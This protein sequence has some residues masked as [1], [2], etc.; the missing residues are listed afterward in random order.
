MTQ[1]WSITTTS[2]FMK[3]KKH[4][5]LLLIHLKSNS[6]SGM[7][8]SLHSIFWCFLHWEGTLSSLINQRSVYHFFSTLAGNHRGHFI[9]ISRTL[10]HR[11]SHFIMLLLTKTTSSRALL[12]R[13]VVE[14]YTDVHIYRLLYIYYTILS[15]LG[16]GNRIHVMGL[17][18]QDRKKW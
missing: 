15:G 11:G 6:F 9:N 7:Q 17:H 10:G 13:F 1:I 14:L 18:N 5:E 8:S 12:H 4:R 2:L 16:G 3:K